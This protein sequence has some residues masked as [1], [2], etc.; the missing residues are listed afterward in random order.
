MLQVLEKLERELHNPLVRKQQERLC[1]LLHPDFR[2]FGKSGKEFNRESIIADMQ[3]DDSA[4]KIWS[5]DYQLQF[6]TENS[7]LIL[8]KSA[9]IELDGSLSSYSIRSSLWIK[10]DSNWKIIFHQGTSTAPFEV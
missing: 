2:E 9:Y 5:G 4:L 1:C 7:A 6:S 8:Y 3:E 10:A